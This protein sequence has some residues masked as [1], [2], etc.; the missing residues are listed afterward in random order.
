MYLKLVK[1]FFKENFSLKRLFGFNLKQNKGKAILIGFALVYALAA[2][3][4]GF[5]FLFFDFAKVLNEI[6]Q[7]HVV[8]SFAVTYVIGLSVMMALFRA[9]GYLFHYKDY[10]ILAPLPFKPYTV[11]LGKITVMLLMIYI[12]SFLIVLPIAFAYFYFN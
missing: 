11:I 10:D 3:L 7:V 6:N 1:V 9:S 2:Y 12:T 5:G 8:L 4:F